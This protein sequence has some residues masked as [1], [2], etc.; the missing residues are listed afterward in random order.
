[1]PFYRRYKVYQPSSWNTQYEEVF[2]RNHWTPTHWR[3]A[4][5]LGFMS[6]KNQCIHHKNYNSLDNRPENLE[7]LLKSEHIKLHKEICKASHTTEVSLKRIASR[8]KTYYSSPELQKRF[9]EHGSSIF[10]N[11]IIREKATK[12]AIA[13]SKSSEG[14]A[15]RKKVGQSLKVK[16][17][18][19][20]L[21][22]K[23]FTTEVCS[24]NGKK[25]NSIY[26][27]SEEGKRKRKELSKIQ[28]VCA[29]NQRT[30]QTFKIIA[31]KNKFKTQERL[32]LKGANVLEYSLSYNHLSVMLGCG[33]NTCKRVFTSVDFLSNARNLK[34]KSWEEISDLTKIKRRRSFI[35]MLNNLNIKDEVMNYNHK[36]KKITVIVQEEDVYDVTVPIYHNFALSSGI[37]VH[38]SS[39]YCD[40]LARVVWEI[41]LNVIQQA[42]QGDYMKPLRHSMPTLRSIANNYEVMNARNGFLSPFGGESSIS[43]S[44][45]GGIFGKGF[46]VQQNIFPNFLVK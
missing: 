33:I 32:F 18:S 45:G 29:R 19:S 12:G 13:F 3:V 7:R 2:T 35:R 10:N 31:D 34:G 39:D 1:M 5:H 24:L 41:Y 46:E 21:A 37:F 20:K 15:L 43:N 26:W 4:K 38:N 36:I 14:R 17:N 25:L 22:K 23:Y 44:S 11:P 42:I 16:A 9:R 6:K 28:L 40:A 8:K 30:K 27:Q